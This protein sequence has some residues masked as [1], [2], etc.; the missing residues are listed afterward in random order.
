MKKHARV[1][2]IGG[3]ALGAGLLYFL[4]KEGWT[5]IV[6]VEKGELTSGSTW[7][8]AGLIPHFIGG[9]S[10]AK[11]HQEGPALYKALE[12]E[13]GQATGWHGCGA[14]RLALTDAEVDW[15]HYVKGIL[16]AVGSECHLISPA[17]IRELHPLLVVDDV[18]MGFYTPNDGHTDPASAT[19]AMA[20]GA[21]MGGAQI[22]RHTQVTGTRLLD[23]GEWEVITDKGNI[24]CEHLVNAAGSFAK[25]V[26]EWVGL[27]LPI[28]N[29]EH[30]Y[31]V[32]DNLPEVEALDREPPV[33]RDPRASCYY[34][35]EQQG[36]LIGPYERAGAQAWGLDG[37]DWGFDMELLSPALER[38]ETSLEH[39]AQRIPC[40]TNAGIKRVVNGPITHTPDGNFLLGP[41]EGLRNYWLCCGAS[42]GITQGPG[43]GKYLAQ[44]MVHGQTEI[45]VRDMDPRRYGKWASGDYAIAKSI[46]E[47]QQMYQP[48]LPGEYRDTGRPTRVTPLYDTLKEAGAVYGDTFG[49][50]RAKWY[51]PK[52]VE[53]E[54]GF[55]RN[56]SFD[57]V[58]QECRA[59]REAVG[60][61]DLTS[62]AK[63]EVIGADAQP[64]LERV[65]A[66]RVPAK[67]GGIVL[68]QMLTMLGGIESEATVTC[69]TKGHYYLLSGAV[70]ELHDL[71]W[72]VQHIKS[73]EDV[74]VRNVTD[75]YGVLVLSGPRS[76]EVLSSLT[77]AGLG[78]G[79]GF[80]WMSAK[81][82]T[83]ADI[84]VR[85]LR[86]SYVG[87]L[88]WELHC[89]MEKLGDLHDA[90]MQAGEA[91]GI[92]R[93]GTYAMNSLRLEKAYKGWG[94][95]LTTEISL[96]EADM[97][98]FARKSGG[99]IGA[100]VIKRKKNEG[101]PIHL[102]YCEVDAD[103]ADPMGN[104]PVLD[105]DDIIGVTTSGAYG[106]T[107]HKSLAFAYVNSGYE[108]PGTTFDVRILGQRRQATVL[109]QAVWDP[110]NERLKC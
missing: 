75:D 18:K 4:T 91:H 107:V 19:N 92:R 80:T 12:A 50:E 27:D 56:N 32:T 61:T 14:I 73:G 109:L 47:Y 82:I 2:I 84:A 90:L 67:I 98:R 57:A 110:T 38:L 100:D 101:V 29:M 97:L 31:L 78:N 69:I 3:G 72:L 62:F 64:F 6:L 49:W 33:V 76:R 28:V 52:G 36:I 46:D 54:Y 40:W 58:A 5:D 13:T 22:Y 20:A 99:Y 89:P 41:S 71:D 35:Q 43:C 24:V 66:N 95:E 44:W 65:C 17:E 103:D 93:F 45:N 106:H 77:D 85:A 9:L 86:V 53:E 74:T 96:V 79:D 87:E 105:G 94:V 83:V 102:I 10:M 11:L 63:Y 88:G 8:A 51:A 7:H 37:I 81:E 48:H 21:R 42:I 30:H 25:Q 59:V 60:L 15:F 34:R 39:A 26:G 16:D 70:A 108:S 23:S 1:V 104:E 55:R 68:S